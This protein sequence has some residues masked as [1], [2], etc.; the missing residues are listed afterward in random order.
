MR[1]TMTV[2]LVVGSAVLP[3]SGPICAEV[4]GFGIKAGLS[5]ANIHGHDVYEQRSRMGFGAGA[6]LTSASALFLPSSRRS[7]SS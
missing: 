4:T 1:R 6:F 5:Y 3:F 7:C 2:L